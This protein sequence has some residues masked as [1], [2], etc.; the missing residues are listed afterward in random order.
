MPIGS[1]LSHFP[2][3]GPCATTFRV[4]QLH[5]KDLFGWSVFDEHRNLDF[6][7][8][9]WIREGG[10]VLVDPVP[11]NDHDL[12]HLKQLGGAAWIVITNSDHA[13]AADALAG[14]LWA[15]LAGPQAEQKTLGIVC[16]RWLADGDEV[17]P[18]M[19]VVEL[20]G[21]KTPGELALVLAPDTLICGD[22]VR[23]HRGG[24][25]NMLPDAK[26]ADKREALASVRRLAE[27]DGIEAVLVGDGWPVFRDGRARLLELLDAS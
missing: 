19:R 15:K 13:R 26:L 11:M 12:T 3:G 23:G 25:L 5:R 7:G 9:A 10:N 24:R 20:A 22:L 14:K 8:T 21:S 18:D 6:H 2:A 4:K 1:N 27:V 17:V 16:D